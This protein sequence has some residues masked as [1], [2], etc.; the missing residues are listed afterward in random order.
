MTEHS[1]TTIENQWI[2]LSD[3]TRLAARIWMPDGADADPVPA[4]FEFLPYRKRDGTSLRDES[5]YPVFAAAGIAG[6]RVDI[7]GS[8]ESEGVIDGEYTE[9]ELA[10]ACELIAWIAAQPW[11]NGSVGMMGISWGG[12]NSLQVAALR[13]PALKA[14]ISIASTVDRYNDDIHYKNGCHLSAQLSWAATML[15]YQSRSPDPAI[16]GDRWKDMWLERLENE[17][18]FM[19]EWLSHQRRDAFWKHGSICEDFSSVEIP[20]L[21]IAG[22][23]DGYRNTPLKAIA[24]LGAGAKA[25]IGPWVHKYP[26]F[27]FPKPRA[28]FHGE[29]IAWWNRWL[30]GEENGAEN[31]P[32]LRAYILDAVRPAPR[33]DADPG[34]WVAM[35][36]W[37]APTMQFFHVGSSGR[38][39]EGKAEPQALAHEVY[40][41]SPLDTGT[42]SGEYFTLKP[43]AEMA[44]DQRGD[45]AGSLTFE[46]APLAEDHDYLGQPVVTLALRCEERTANLCVRLVDVHEDGTATRVSFGVLN[47]AH[48]DGN[49][50]PKPVKSGERTSVRLLLDAC[51]YRFRAGHRIR[52]SLSTAYW[53]MILPPPTDPGLVIDTASIELALPIL[54]DHRLIAVNEPDNPDPLPKYIEHAPAETKRQVIRELSANRTEYRIHEDT[55]LFEHPDTGLSTRQVRDE[56][57]SISPDDPL[58]MTGISTWTCDMQRPGWFVRTVAVSAISCTAKDWVISASV[59]AYEGETRIFEKIFEKKRIPRDLM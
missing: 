1:F 58:S 32:Q 41:R 46:T 14:V 34:F 10:N 24:G 22:W 42:A 15:G 23:A 20:A 4:V 27:A 8:G 13:P 33:R 48:R 44:I 12:F 18:F 26:H 16:V 3:G 37:H 56:T 6:V 25:L 39:E 51:G 29:A 55:G 7:R 21:V 19:E 17:P 28:D 50:E 31:T 52:L 59:I 43:D 49:A 35:D 2:T 11:S 45:D 53:P 30:R 36:I 57:W 5:T 47:L 38:I 9:L 40:L 54:T